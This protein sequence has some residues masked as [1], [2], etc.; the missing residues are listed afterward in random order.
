MKFIKKRFNFNM[1]FYGMSYSPSILFIVNEDWFV[2]VLH[3]EYLSIRPD[4]IQSH[5]RHHQ[6]PHHLHENL[7]EWIAE[8]K[9]PF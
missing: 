7:P 8:G 1:D 4:F 5:S 6:S 9:H 3:K 2:M